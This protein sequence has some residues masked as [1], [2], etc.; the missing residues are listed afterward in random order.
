MGPASESC[1]YQLGWRLAPSR[2]ADGKRS[3]SLPR[4]DAV[5][6]EAGRPPV[7]GDNKPWLVRSRQ[8]RADQQSAPVTR[9]VGTSNAASHDGKSAKLQND[10][11][12]EA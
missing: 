11:V 10:T 4:A 2:A 9:I 5:R 8:L 1:E 3:P 7:S 6:P 12:I